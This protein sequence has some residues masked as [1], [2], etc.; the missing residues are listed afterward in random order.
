[1]AGCHSFCLFFIFYSIYTFIQSHSYNTFAEASLHFLIACKLSGKNL[2]VVPS[3]ESNSGLPS[4]KPTRWTPWFQEII[5][6][7]LVFSHWQTSHGY[8]SSVPFH[9]VMKLAVSCKRSVTKWTAVR[10]LS[11]VQSQMGLKGIILC[12]RFVTNW[13]VS[14]QCAFSHDP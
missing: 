8:L 3:R 12:K 5:K 14:L 4:S 10:F 2:P 7:A 13:T 1:M 11:C 9:V 6:R